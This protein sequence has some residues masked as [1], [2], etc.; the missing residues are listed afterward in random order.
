MRL[1]TATAAALLIAGTSVSGAGLP[2][3]EDD[4]AAHCLGEDADFSPEGISACL[5]GL[6]EARTESCSTFL[7]LLE[8]CSSEIQPGAVCGSDYANGDGVPC[9]VQRTR[10]AQGY[11]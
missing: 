9:L 10:S 3:C 11:P 2:S 5:A 8:A 1:I 7:S 4:T 6:G